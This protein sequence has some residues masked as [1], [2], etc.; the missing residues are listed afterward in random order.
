LGHG[1][2][3]L[4]SW[5]DSRSFSSDGSY[6]SISFGDLHDYIARRGLPYAI[7]PN[8][9]RALPFRVGVLRLVQSG[10]PFLLPQAFLALMDVIGTAF[11]GLALPKPKRWPTFQGVD[12][13]ALILDD[14][15]RDWVLARYPTNV[16]LM[17]IVRRWNT[18]GIPVESFI[19]S[20]E[21]HI[22]EKAYCMAF[23]K[24]YPKARLVGYQDA[25]LPL[26]LL[27]FFV[28]NHETSKHPFPDV[29]VT[30][31]RYSFDLLSQ[32][33]KGSTELRCGGALRH[34]YLTDLIHNGD[35]IGSEGDDQTRARFKTV[36]VATSLSE[37]LACELLYKVI[38]ALRDETTVRVV[39]KCHPGLPFDALSK[40][41]GID[42]LPSHFEIS[43][44]PV[45]ELLR[46]CT[47]LVYMD[48]T[49]SLEGLA[50]GTPVIH[51]ASDFSLDFDPLESIP[52]SRLSV[53]TIVELRSA[54][55]SHF[56]NWN[57][58]TAERIRMRIK[59][60]SQFLGP[61]DVSSYACF[62]D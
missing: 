54:I 52:G 17:A 26:M 21:N 2:V 61:I 59:M 60:V 23:R 53:R 42:T 30:N 15:R 19:Y 57:A 35:R 43:N 37:T 58:L 6:Q 45:S 1:L 11:Q 14:Q 9:L 25:N 4:H 39:V 7:V 49:T 55:L 50:I 44:Q 27:N 32:A 56:G 48:S 40:R 38:V 34:K 51:V 41:L 16:L 10:I 20:F 12:I 13:S 31:G 22:W 3:L 18:A 36:L 62:L 5:I 28:S 47:I 46:A 29:I 33:G 24:Y 8:I